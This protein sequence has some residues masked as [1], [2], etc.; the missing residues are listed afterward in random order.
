MHL[1]APLRQQSCAGA[2]GVSQPPAQLSPLARSS[3]P[4]PPGRP[5]AGRALGALVPCSGGERAGGS[6]RQP[7]SLRT[8]GCGQA[9]AGMGSNIHTHDPYKVGDIKTLGMHE[10]GKVRQRCG[11]HASGG[12]RLYGDRALAWIAW[13]SVSPA[14]VLRAAGAP[15][16]GGGGEAGAAA[17]AAAQPARAAALRV[18][19]AQRQSAG[20]RGC[21]LPH[22]AS[23]IA[24]CWGPPLLAPK[25]GAARVQQTKERCTG[26]QRC[27]P[28]AARR[29]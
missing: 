22:S 17:A 27:A 12:L 20:A 2:G 11:Q 13:A 14:P 21:G 4:A 7:H 5:A 25:R 26:A 1:P 23:A 6:E 29:A 28:L 10:D 19:P 24:G 15:A 9:G 16:A 18:L 3:A 8:S